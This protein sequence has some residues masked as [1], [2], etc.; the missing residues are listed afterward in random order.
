MEPD[1][2]MRAVEGSQGGDPLEA[3]KEALRAVERERLRA[4]VEADMEV[5]DR[6]HA[7]DFQLITPSGDALSKQ[8]YLDDVASRWLHYT[9]FE[10]D[11]PIETRISGQTAVIRY[12]SRIEISSAGKPD[13][14]AFWHTDT[15]EK[16]KGH[17]QAVWSQATRIM[18]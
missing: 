4:L 16:R 5:A 1:H 3:E 13:A 9:V 2:G 11:S 7:E 6:L 14:G 10:P 15:Y 18:R 12:R 17:W 8:Q